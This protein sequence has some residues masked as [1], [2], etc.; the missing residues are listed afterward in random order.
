MAG[1]A[2]RPHFNASGTSTKS[3]VKAAEGHLYDLE[4][5]NPTNADAFIQI[6]DALTGAVTVGT[7]TP[8][9]SLLV[10]AGNG[11]IRGAMDKHFGEEGLVFT[12]GIVYACTTTPT[13][14]T[15]PSSALNVNA[16]WS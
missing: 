1:H 5:S 3:V 11:T 14:S 4:V 10:P 15:A 16:L 9:L 2:R 13:G 12:S 8:T 7:T 6:F